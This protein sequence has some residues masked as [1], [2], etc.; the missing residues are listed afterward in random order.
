MTDNNMLLQNASS[1]GNFVEVERIIM[2]ADPACDYSLA[3]GAA[4]YSGHAQCVA[5]L[6]PH[7]KTAWGFQLSLAAVF[8]HHNVVQTLIPFCADTPCAYD[9]AL[10]FAVS[11]NHMGYN[12]MCI[13]LLIPISNPEIALNILEKNS[14]DPPRWLNLLLA[15]LAEVQR[16][17][18]EQSLN[19]CE[20]SKSSLNVMLKI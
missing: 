3:L 1:C 13:E 9:Q 6:A 19:D 4:V 14:S 18:I 5:A 15:R 20:I 16:D 7:C 2:L 17:K 12:D 11:E 10:E 8:G